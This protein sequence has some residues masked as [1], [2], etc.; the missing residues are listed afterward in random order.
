METKGKVDVLAL[1][2]NT[3][4]MLEE[5]GARM[6]GLSVKSARA[7]VAD[8]IEAAERS[9]N[10][11]SSYPGNGAIGAY[12]QM[13]AALSALRSSQGGREGDEGE[14]RELT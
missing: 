8:L 3:A 10:W 12:D 5:G 1:L 4:S 11:L 13:R 7:A 9:L 6:Y 2:D 14:G